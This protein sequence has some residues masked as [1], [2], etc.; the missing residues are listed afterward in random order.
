MGPGG[1][2]PRHRRRLL[3]RALAALGPRPLADPDRA[4]P[5]RAGWP[6][7][8]RAGRDAASG[9]AGGRSCPGPRCSAHP[10]STTACSCR[11]TRSWP[12]RWRSS[13]WCAGASWPGSC[14][15]ASP[16]RC[17]GARWCGRCAAS[18]R[19]ASR[20]GAGS[21]PGS[22]ASST[23][24]PRPSRSCRRCTAAAPSGEQVV[25]AGAD[26]LNMTGSIIG[27][28]RVPTR[29][30]QRVVVPRRHRGGPPRGRVTRA[31]EADHRPERRR[32][33]GDRRRRSSR[34]SAPCSVSS[35][36]RTS[37]AAAMPATRRPWR[38][39]WPPPSSTRCGSG[40]TPPIPTGR[41]SGAARWRS[42][43]ASSR[44]SLARAAARRLDRVCRSAGTTI[45]SVKPHGALYEEVAKGGAIYETLR[46]AV[47]DRC[48]DGTRW[49]CRRVAAPWRWPCATACRR[50]RRGSATGRT[51]T[52]AA[53][54]SAARPARSSATP[55][56]AA[57]QALSLARGAVV[58]ND[59]SVLT[60]WVDT[61]CVHGDAAGRSGHRHGG[62]PCAGGRGHR[63]GRAG[64]CM[65]RSSP[66]GRCASS[67]TVPS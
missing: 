16:S 1:P 38:P 6:G 46:D 63:R 8:R 22:P 56:T 40:P 28:A 11:A 27:G 17:R 44:D 10:P 3:G 48:G 66:S 33:R 18:R 42:T 57:A 64:A 54:S 34:R 41:G 5:R 14:G 65:T 31:D 23:R 43:G 36:R 51:A 29:R 60:L 47:R 37:P 30:N 7:R 21:W 39:R 45:E 2:R 19:A 55:R 12:R 61:L 9:R 52:T 4:P 26:P 20:S 67:V 58:A 35:P 53:W 25:V 15:A 32:R 13:C 59:G 24:C 50:A 49:S 62:A